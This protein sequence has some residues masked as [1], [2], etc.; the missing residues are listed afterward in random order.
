MYTSEC[1]KNLKCFWRIGKKSLQIKFQ[2]SN[3]T[4]KA[5]QKSLWSWE[6]SLLELLPYT[7][8]ATKTHLQDECWYPIVPSKFVNIWHPLTILLSGHGL[9]TIVPPVMPFLQVITDQFW[10]AN[11]LCMWI[12]LYPG[13]RFYHKIFTLS[14]NRTT[15]R[16]SEATN[17]FL[18]HEATII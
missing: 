1:K 18:I 8:L 16:K 14:R 15:S 11:F 2:N 12:L 17:F 5:K 6:K 3:W 9:P 7:K 4:E 10:T 13:G